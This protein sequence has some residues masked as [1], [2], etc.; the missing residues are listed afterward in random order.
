VRCSQA[1]KR[2]KF[3]LRVLDKQVGY[4][5]E[6]MDLFKAEE[7]ADYGGDIN[8]H[9]RDEDEQEEEDLQEVYDDGED[10]KKQI[11]ETEEAEEEADNDLSFIDSIVDPS[12]CATRDPA[13]T[14]ASL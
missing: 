7:A 5:E 6:I 13:F 3:I 8:N 14:L 10:I 2:A 4:F 12:G 9:D 11:I 1:Y